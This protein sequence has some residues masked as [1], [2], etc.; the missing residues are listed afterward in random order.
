[1]TYLPAT[2]L[3]WLKNRFGVDSDSTWHAVAQSGHRALCGAPPGRRGEGWFYQAVGAQTITCDKCKAKIALR[4][5]HDAK[6][7]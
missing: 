2:Q 4:R 6:R 5:A 7:R 3:G 1:M